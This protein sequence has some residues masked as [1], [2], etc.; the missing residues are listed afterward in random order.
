MQDK[1]VIQR[2]WRDW[3]AQR[4]TALGWTPEF[5][6]NVGAELAKEVDW[7]VRVPNLAG[8]LAGRIAKFNSQLTNFE[9]DLAGFD[10]YWQHRLAFLGWMAA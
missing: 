1:L 10:V 9:G 8:N 3:L 7:A 6:S 4:A 5:T 2:T